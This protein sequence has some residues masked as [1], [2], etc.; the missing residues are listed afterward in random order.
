MFTY[1]YIS[2]LQNCMLESSLNRENIFFFLDKVHAFNLDLSM[3]LIGP[4]GQVYSVTRD[5]LVC[6]IVLY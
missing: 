6:N 4:L 5:M 2:H 3:W 1:S